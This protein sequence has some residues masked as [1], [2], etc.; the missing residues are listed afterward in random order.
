[1][2][3]YISSLKTISILFSYLVEIKSMHSSSYFFLQLSGMAIKGGGDLVVGQ[4]YT[5]FDKGYEDGIEGDI[6]G[7][8]L[9]HAFTSVTT[10]P[11]PEFPLNNIHLAR[12][13][14]VAA[15]SNKMRFKRGILDVFRSMI[16]FFSPQPNHSVRLKSIEE[17]NAEQQQ[18]MHV[19]SR[20][21]PG[22]N[23]RILS[24]SE[25]GAKPLGLYLVE[26][27]YNCVLGKGAPLN[28]EKVLVS[29]TKT[30]VRVFGGA[31]LKPEI[32]FCIGKK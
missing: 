14:N 1:M 28:G 9:V 19:M 13:R 10:L 24:N 25:N 15:L 4:E 16:N 5:D 6:F 31:I 17:F 8:N 18:R 30:T 26:M 12:K 32:P 27:G 29:W 2:L 7:F 22:A 11:H 21:V 23:S 3:L 20:Y